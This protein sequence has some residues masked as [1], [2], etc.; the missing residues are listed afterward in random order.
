MRKAPNLFR[1]EDL[2]QDASDNW[3]Q[4][5][6]S[7]VLSRPIGFFS[8]RNRLRLAWLVFCGRADAVTWSGNQ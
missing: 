8:I 6:G 4:I 5:D 3:A 2:L 1:I 7:W